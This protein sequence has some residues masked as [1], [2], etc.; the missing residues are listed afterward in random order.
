M[1][2]RNQ[3]LSPNDKG[4]QRRESLGTRLILI[5]YDKQGY[6]SQFVLEL[7]DILQK[8]TSRGALQCDLNNLC[9]HGNILG[10]RPP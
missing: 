3:G 5:K 2:S 6:L 4:R 7:L 9:C 10:S 1:T 8:D